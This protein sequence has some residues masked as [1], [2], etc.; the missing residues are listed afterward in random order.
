MNNKIHEKAH[1][2]I[3]KDTKTDT[4]RRITQPKLIQKN[5]TNKTV[6][7]TCHTRTNNV[8]RFNVVFSSQGKDPSV[9]TLMPGFMN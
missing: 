2:I 3:Q 9:T 8:M 7:N 6:L 4:K 5:K 1:T